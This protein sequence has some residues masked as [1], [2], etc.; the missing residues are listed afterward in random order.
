LFAGTN[1]DLRP[2]AAAGG[3]L[4]MWHGWADTGSTPHHSLNYY[5]AVRRFMGEAEAAKV[6]ALY[7]IPGV[8]HCNGGPRATREDF[9]TQLMNW[10]EDGT[11]PARVDVSYY[12]T[13][14]I[15][16]PVALVRPVWP[17]PSIA[18]YTG[19]G[20]V[21]DP[22]NFVR[23]ART[24]AQTFVDRYEWLGIANYV[25]GKQIS[26]EPVGAGLES[27]VECKTGSGQAVDAGDGGGCTIGNGRFDPM[28]VCLVGLAAVSLARRRTLGG[29]KRSDSSLVA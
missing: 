5:D 11:A 6:M 1:P 29:R 25:P 27:S 28:L 15:T 4:L 22:A 23:S 2:F 9:L 3:K 13:N 12:T 18:T 24:T 8:Y 16:S 17:Y 21:S 20:A 10:V 14:V 26:C 7:M 19:S